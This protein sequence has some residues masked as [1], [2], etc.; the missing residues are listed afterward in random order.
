MGVNQ[1]RKIQTVF[2]RLLGS[3]DA[4]LIANMTTESNLYHRKI[5]KNRI[6]KNVKVA[7]YNRCINGKFCR[8]VCNDG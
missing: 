5:L 4:D 8:A 3:I 1:F 7:R 6:C 2:M